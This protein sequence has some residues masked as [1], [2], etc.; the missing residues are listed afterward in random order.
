MK[1]KLKKL[2]GI[3]NLQA[4]EILGKKFKSQKREQI[5]QN[6]FFDSNL[7]Q[8]LFFVPIVFNFNKEKW[9]FSTQ[10]F[11]LKTTW[12]KIIFSM[13][14]THRIPPWKVSN[15]S[16]KYLSLEI[17]TGIFKYFQE[18]LQSNTT[19]FLQSHKTII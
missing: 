9:I 2:I 14:S 8:K 19:Q 16:S 15:F 11:F 6:L 4:W 1:I 5:L 18:N 12:I 13:Q 10:K 7:K 17:Y 3:E